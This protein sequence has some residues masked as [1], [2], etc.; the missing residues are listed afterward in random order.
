M[1]R[2]RFKELRYCKSTAQICSINDMNF[3]KKT[4]LHLLLK[5]IVQQLKQS[6]LQLMSKTT[7]CPQL[8]RQEI[9]LDRESQKAFNSKDLPGVVLRK[10]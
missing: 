6:D 5:K 1:H 7:L 9:N 3:S 2:Y 8:L 10:I 4:K